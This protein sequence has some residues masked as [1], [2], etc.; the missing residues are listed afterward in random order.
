MPL[1]PYQNV[2]AK[3]HLSSEEVCLRISPITTRR[4]CRMVF[5]NWSALCV[6]WI[7]GSS[8]ARKSKAGMCNRFSRIAFYDFGRHSFCLMPRDLTFRWFAQRCDGY[9]H[10][11]FKTQQTL[12]TRENNLLCVLAWDD[13]SQ[14]FFETFFFFFFFWMKDTTGREKINLNNDSDR[15]REKI[16][17]FNY[18]WAFFPRLN[19]AS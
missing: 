9:R 17:S 10:E 19:D 7:T 16:I 15:M 1:P 4:L 12:C 6:G 13:I 11:H 3:E 8:Q 5:W 2:S 14:L 18:A